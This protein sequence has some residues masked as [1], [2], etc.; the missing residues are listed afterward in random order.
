MSL[1]HDQFEELQTLL[2]QF[3]LD[4]LTEEQADRLEELASSSP[5]AC[6]LYIQWACVHAGLRFCSAEAYEPAVDMPAEAPPATNLPTLVLEPQPSASP[7]SL[8]GDAS[9]S[10]TANFLQGWP[11][12]YLI[13][14]VIFGV[15]L[16][17]ASLLTVTHHVYMAQQPS[18]S[19]SKSQ[20]AASKTEYIGQIT[21]MVDVKWADDSTAALGGARVPLGRK[22]ALASGLMEITYDTGAK[23]ILQGPATYRVE[24][25]TGG[26]LSIG[27]LTARLEK[28]S[29]ISGQQSASAASVANHKSLASSPQP[30]APNANPQ[31]LIPNPSLSTLPTPLFTIKTPSATVTDLGTE[32]GV[33]AIDNDTTNVH[34]F[35]GSVSVSDKSNLAVQ[36]ATAGQAV[37]VARGTMRHVKTAPAPQQFV[38][39]IRIPDLLHDD[40]NANTLDPLKWTVK[41]MIPGSQGTADVA[42]RNGRIELANRGYLVTKRQYHP[43]RLGGIKIT[44]RWTFHNSMDMLQILTRSD[45]SPTRNDQGETAEG[46]EF[47]LMTPENDGDQVFPQIL[48]HG[49]GLTLGK[50]RMS[51]GLHVRRGDAFDFTIIDNGVFGVAFTL[52]QVGNPSNTS[53][54]TA[55]LNFH[56]TSRQHVVFH[57]RESVERGRYAAWLD[58][59]TITAPAKVP[60]LPPARRRPATLAGYWSFNGTTIDAS[61]NRNHGQGVETDY[62]ND[63]PRVLADRAARSIIFNGTSSKVSVPF[64]PSL[65]INDAVTIAFWMK[66]D[67]AQQTGVYRRVF[68]NLASGGRGMEIQQDATTSGLSIRLDTGDSMDSGFNQCTGI[69]TAFDGVWHHVAVTA[70]SAGNIT[71]YFDGFPHDAH[72]HL[73][74]R[75]WQHVGNALRQQRQ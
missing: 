53:T 37:H 41:T 42:A 72:V 19:P 14:S 9:Q 2:D 4:E 25:R 57:N 64:S 40:F 65:H 6:D 71:T 70:D 31:S 52:A 46:L 33:E 63:V 23:V 50:V 29:A 39:E 56:N 5:E 49:I 62:V 48:C 32:F 35:M 16:Y 58:D 75:L 10:M 51:G 74:R 38:R 54:I 61:G 18:A 69:G 22:Y 73:R 45:G 44:G 27:R 17:V 43:D 60:P 67:A 59:V 47:F 24:S 36:L 55:A 11:M 20:A 8:F 66:A 34:V 1:S 68:S 7:M 12:A 30:L 13:G 3:S 28:Q 21:G 26:F 15:G